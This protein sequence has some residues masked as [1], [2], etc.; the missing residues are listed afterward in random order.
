MIMGVLFLY[1]L[2]LKCVYNLNIF[3]IRKVHDKVVD[4]NN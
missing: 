2:K 3:M 1:D 4:I